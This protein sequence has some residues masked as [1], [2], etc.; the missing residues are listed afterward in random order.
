MGKR[1]VTV[2]ESR[3]CA[4][5]ER[6]VEGVSAATESIGISEIDAAIAKDVS[7]GAVVE[8]MTMGVLVLVS[9]V[10]LSIA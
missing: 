7:I 3:G 4:A 5:G 10:V 6:E 8:A 1:G 9:A 2:V